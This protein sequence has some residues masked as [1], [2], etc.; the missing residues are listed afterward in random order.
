MVNSN[1]EKITLDFSKYEKGKFYDLSFEVLYDK[2]SKNV[3][4]EETMKLNF[5]N[6]KREIES[7]NRRGKSIQKKIEEFDSELVSKTLEWYSMQKRT[8]P[9]YDLFWGD[10]Y[11]RYGKSEL[12]KNIYK[13]ESDIVKKSLIEKEQAVLNDK[14]EFLEHAT[15]EIFQNKLDNTLNIK[16]EFEEKIE[17]RKEAYKEILPMVLW[18]IKKA[19]EKLELEDNDE[20]LKTVIKTTRKILNDIEYKGMYVGGNINE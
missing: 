9:K 7:L 8:K 20:T 16:K 10:S 15:K 19:P 18:L 14:Y 5:M 2:D 6:L 3:L 17:K 11:N 4:F 13:I 12:Q 1:Y